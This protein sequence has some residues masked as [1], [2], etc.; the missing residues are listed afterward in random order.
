MKG[1]FEHIEW[2][3]QSAA[4]R[5]VAGAIFLMNLEQKSHSVGARRQ[6]A[7]CRS[8]QTGS[9]QLFLDWIWLLLISAWWKASNITKRNKLTIRATL[10]VSFEKKM[11]S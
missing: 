5:K 10:N 7:A 8:S 4:D 6:D 11:M 2:T 9:V 1:P 3:P